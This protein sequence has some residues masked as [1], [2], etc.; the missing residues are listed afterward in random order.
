[1]RE[2]QRRQREFRPP[3][4]EDVELD[5]HC[6][7]DIRKTLQGVQ[8]LHSDPNF[9]EP[10]FKLLDERLLPDA[11]RRQGRPG[12]DLRSILVPGIVKQAKRMDFDTLHDQANNHE[13]LRLLLGTA[14]LR[15]DRHCSRKALERN[16]DRPRPNFSK[17]SASCP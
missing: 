4:T 6:R 2:V 11:D 16:I 15:D 14:D 8:D 10:V 7:D 12:T 5:L 13:K 3:L 1:M 9:R 17:R